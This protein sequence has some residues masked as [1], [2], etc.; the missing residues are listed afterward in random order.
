MAST[1]GKLRI[2]AIA[3]SR[4]PP[5]IRNWVRRSSSRFRRAASSKVMKVL[6][7]E[8]F[9]GYVGR[10]WGHVSR[11]RW[12]VLFMHVGLSAVRYV[13]AVLSRHQDDIRPHHQNGGVGQPFR[14]F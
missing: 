8:H 1:T 5:S 6:E 2:R 11:K 12:N 4:P 9:M 10:M 13:F 3:E 14:F 7:L